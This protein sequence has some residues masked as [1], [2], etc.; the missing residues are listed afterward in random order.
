[1]AAIGKIRVCVLEGHQA[2]LAS[3]GLPLSVCLRLQQLDLSMSA[4]LWSTRQT[5]GGFSVSFFWPSSIRGGASQKKPRNRRR[6]CR[7]CRKDE[8]RSI[9]LPSATIAP[10]TRPAP[11]KQA[12]VAQASRTRTPINAHLSAHC[13]SLSPSRLQAA[14]VP[15]AETQQSQGN[16]SSET[17]SPVQDKPTQGSQDGGDWTLVTPRRRKRGRGQGPKVPPPPYFR[18][19]FHLWPPSIQQK[20]PQ[21]T[22]SASS[23]SSASSEVSEDENS[24]IASRTRARTMQ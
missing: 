7:K 21:A 8:R 10:D 2:E 9:V 3:A 6:K 12:S 5:N 22:S 18:M 16:N 11:A 14:T 20:Y 24:P 1:M 13:K 4:A 23:A 19:P 17:S 15:L